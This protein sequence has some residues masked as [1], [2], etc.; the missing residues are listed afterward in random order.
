LNPG[1]QEETMNRGFTLIE[2]MITLAV[3]MLAVLANARVLTAA[4]TQSRGAALRFRLVDKLEFYKNYLASRPFA[5]VELAA[6]GHE[7]AAD[8]AAIEWRV[9]DSSPTLKWLRL[10]ASSGG[11]SLSLAML[12]SRFLPEARP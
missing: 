12:R 2:T 7:G 9:R 3:V 4:L 6:G 1:R 11:R 10:R 5:A 8:G